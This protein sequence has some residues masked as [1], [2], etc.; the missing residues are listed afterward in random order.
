MSRATQLYA[1]T[2][3]SRE[4]SLALRE[5]L[6]KNRCAVAFSAQTLAQLLYAERYVSR[7]VAAHEVEV[8]LE[9]LHVGDGEA[10]A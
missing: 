3:D 7:R 5:L 1:T 8:A 2:T 9:A 4:L 6:S 10:L